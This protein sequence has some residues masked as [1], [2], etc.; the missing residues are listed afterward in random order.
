MFLDEVEE[1]FANIGC[2][3][4]VVWWV[5]PDDLTFPVSVMCSLL[6]L[7]WL[8]LQLVVVPRSFEGF[9]VECC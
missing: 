1:E 6:L 5:E 4:F 9:I 3:V 2:Q 7:V 8:E